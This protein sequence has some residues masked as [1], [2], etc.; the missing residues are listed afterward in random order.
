LKEGKYT[1]IVIDNERKEREKEK[2]RKR[3]EE[4][5]TG[6]ISLLDFTR[7]LV[8]LTVKKH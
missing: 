6:D 5:K 7:Q 2:K 3:L 1:K 4:K 8:V